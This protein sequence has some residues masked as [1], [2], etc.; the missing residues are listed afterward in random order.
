MDFILEDFSERSTIYRLFWVKNYKT[1]IRYTSSY[2]KRKIAELDKKYDIIFVIRGEAISE[3]NMT[4]LKKRYPFAK[5]IMYQWDSIK[6]N[7]NCLRIERFFDKIF[8]FDM[9]DA[10]KKGWYYRPL[11]YVEEN[12]SNESEKD[13]DFSMIGTLYYKRA[14]LLKKIREYCSKNNFSLFSYMYSPKLVYLIHKY[15]MHDSKYKDI[16][17]NDVKF[18]QM[19]STDLSAVYDKSAILVD[20]TAD[21]QTGLT[22]RTIES[23]GHHCKLI[24]NNKKIKDCDIYESGNIYVY[25]LDCFSVPIEFVNSRYN[26]LSGEMRKYYSLSGWITSIF[27]LT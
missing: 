7:K 5:F 27:D 2:Y 1:K 18:Q 23:I 20:Y 25:D 16:P 22:M 8:T 9:E 6:N 24:T 26:E 15:I 21:N 13:I 4:Q 12:V 14:M 19:S 17:Y 3:E 11:F 10:Q